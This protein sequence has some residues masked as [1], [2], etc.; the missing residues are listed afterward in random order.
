MSKKL[1]YYLGLNNA[2]RGEKVLAAFLL[3][4]FLLF[5]SFYLYVG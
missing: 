1:K 5:A 4:A 2:T 3:V